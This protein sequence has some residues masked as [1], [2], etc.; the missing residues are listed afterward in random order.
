[1]Y[2]QGPLLH[3]LA[4][5]LEETLDTGL[6]TQLEGPGG[7][8]LSILQDPVGNLLCSRGRAILYILGALA[9]KGLRDQQDILKGEQE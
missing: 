9:G 2:N 7:F 4:L 8:V 1:M 5:Q 6:L 3:T